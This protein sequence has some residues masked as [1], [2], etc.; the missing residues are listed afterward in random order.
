MKNGDQESQ[1]NTPI[2]VRENFNAL[3]VFAASVPTDTNGHAK[4]PVKLPDNLTRYRVMAV[5]VAGGKQFGAGESTITAR[6]PLM[7]RPSAPRFLNFGDKFELPVVVQN[8]TDKTIEVEVGVRASNAELTN[9]SGRRVSV[10]ANDRVEIRFPATTV[11]AGVARF[12]IGAISGK[13]SDAAEVSLPVWTPATTEAFATYGEVDEQG[14]VVQPI[15]APS[16]VFNQFGGIEITTSSTQLQELTDAV[17]YLVSYPFECS[18][19]LA[20]RV[21]G[22]AAL[23]DVLTA[24]EA[25]DLPTPKAMREAVERDINMLKTLQQDNGGFGFWRRNEK[26]WPYVSIHVA[27][28]LQRAKAK[29]FHVPSEMLDKSRTYLR[30][31]ESHIPSSYSRSARNALIAYALYVRNLM[32]DK[33][34]GRARKLI[35]EEKL[36]NLSLESIGWLLSVLS[37][38]PKSQTEVQAIHTHLNNR[39]TETAATAH[40]VSSYSDD[41]YLLLHSDRRAD[42][43]I[44][45]ALIE[46][47]PKNDLIP[48]IVRGLLAHRTKGRWENTQE[49][50]FILLALDRYFATYEKVT[51]AFVAKAWLGDRF[52]GDHEFKGRTTDSHLINVP[53][54][55]LAS[56]QT[57]Q[58]LVI[59]KEGAGRLYY[60]IGMKYAPTSLKLE[61][62]EHG[63]TVQRVYEG[64]DKADDVRKAED[65]TWHIKAGAKIRVKLTL[66]APTRRY[67]VALV[68]P[69]PAGLESLNPALAV[70]GTLPDDDSTKIESWWWSRPWF[71]HQNLR[72]E[73][74]EAFT[75]LLWEGVYTYSYI[76]LATTPGIFIVPPAKAEEM[77][78][79]E[80]FGRSAS[81]KVVVE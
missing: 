45:E 62:A 43:V 74:A 73:R 12:Q 32:G 54:R 5:S 24:F 17:L 11:R 70:T 35:V 34:P 21:L 56:A 63:L 61:P 79:P 30:R 1:S 25:K 37:K 16:N 26:Q 78:H 52:A 55:Y 41:N 19:Q 29:D 81:D 9:G 77:Y 39:A 20:S 65:G 31:I 51:P 4:V 42:G 59:A 23:K 68:D 57:D 2:N 46:D 38:D 27:H 33:D 64:V 40:F 36:E 8:Q 66:I 72:D 50:V 58:N 48:K 15:K 44:L 49:N 3:A 6:L 75:S 67:H 18:E 53:M 28:A 60:R 69:M 22:V 76:A 13:W 80:T 71:E 10:P 47:Q 14:A 7:V